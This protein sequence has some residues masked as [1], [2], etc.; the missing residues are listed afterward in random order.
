[1]VLR[2][3]GGFS[4]RWSMLL[5]NTLSSLALLT[6][7]AALGCGGEVPDD[8]SGG[9][10]AGASSQGG[11]GGTPS[12]GGQG[13]LGGDGGTPAT[14]GGGASSGGGGAG[15]EGGAPEVWPDCLSQPAGSPTKTLPQIWAD[16]P[17]APAEAWVPGV[18]VTAIS[19]G[20]CAAG[21]ACQFFVQQEESYASL[22]QAT[23]QSLRVGVAGSVSSYFTELQVGDQVD[24]YA[25]AFRDTQDGKNELIFLVTP[26]L[27][28]CAAVIGAGDPQPVLAT[29]D[30]LTLSAYEDT[31][32]PV[33]VQIDT[34]TGTPKTPPE[35]FGLKDTGGQFGDIT[36]VTSLSPY[37]LPGA[38]FSGLTA[39]VE[40]DFESVIGVFGIFAPPADPLIKYEEIYVRSSAD[41]PLAN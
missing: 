40:T 1:M 12:V 14:G 6:F 33:L 24:L 31:M 11:M 38:A 2:H 20:G 32:G 5:R 9:G 17:A 8:A 16:D 7:S 37:F 30:D 22:A 34:V 27:P 36:L 3:A 18:Y 25:H 41:Y 39:D 29:L 28:G 19:N 26:A 4:K 23:H 15:G 10:G 35:T 21:T 13:G